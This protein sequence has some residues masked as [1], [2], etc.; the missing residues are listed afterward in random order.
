MYFLKT[1]TTHFTQHVQQQKPSPSELFPNHTYLLFLFSLLLL[2]I[3]SRGSIFFDCMGIF[4][5]VASRG[6]AKAATS[7]LPLFSV[8][9]TLTERGTWLEVVC[10]GTT[11]SSVLGLGKSC[12]LALQKKKRKDKQTQQQQTLKILCTELISTSGTL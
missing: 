12:G 10:L 5:L 8:G 7:S 3:V 1:K 2:I 6:L 9:H 11:S 4:C